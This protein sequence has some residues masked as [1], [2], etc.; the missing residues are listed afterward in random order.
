MFTHLYHPLHIHFQRH[1]P[2]LQLIRVK[3]SLAKSIC[4]WGMV[5]ISYLEPLHGFQAQSMISVFIQTGPYVESTVHLKLF[6]MI[7]PK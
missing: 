1:F 7:Q 2:H 4:F 6:F 3:L 5:I